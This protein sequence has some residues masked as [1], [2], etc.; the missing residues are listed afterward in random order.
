LA[1]LFNEG[2]FKVLLVIFFGPGT[3]GD[4]GLVSVERL[5]SEKCSVWW[6][7]CSCSLEILFFVRR[8]LSG[9]VGN[10]LVVLRTAL[11]LL[12]GCDIGLRIN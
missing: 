2:L 3:K 7:Y 6:F 11:V 4:V 1:L 8:L 10:G 12:L 9:P 5:L